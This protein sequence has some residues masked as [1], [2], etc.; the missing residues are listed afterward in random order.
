M[1][2]TPAFSLFMFFTAFYYFTN[3]GWYEAGDGFFMTPLPNRLLKT[4]N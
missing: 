4:D 3:A 1:F 2:Q